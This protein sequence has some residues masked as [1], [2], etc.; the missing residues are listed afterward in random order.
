MDSGGVNAEAIVNVGDVI[1]EFLVF[2]DLSI[3]LGV[4]LQDKEFDLGLVTYDVELVV[5]HSD[6]SGSR[7]QVLHFPC[8][9]AVV[10]EAEMK[11]HGLA[12]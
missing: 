8:A 4:L 7:L 3:G 1:N 12:L 10:A 2:Q 11:G 9:K 6:F 5:V